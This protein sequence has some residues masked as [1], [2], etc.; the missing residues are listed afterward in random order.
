MDFIKDL[1]KRKPEYYLQAK[2]MLLWNYLQYLETNDL[3][4][5]SDYHNKKNVKE[6]RIDLLEQ[7][8]TDIYGEILEITKRFEVLEKFRKTHKILKNNVKYNAVM[9][10]IKSIYEY[11]N[12]LGREI[13]LEKIEMIRRW[14]YKISQDKDLFDQ[15]D[16][17]AKG[18]QA[19]KTEVEVLESELIKENKTEKV[20]FEKQR[21]SIEMGLELKIPIDPMKDSVERWFILLVELEK[22]VE[23]LSK[24][25]N[26]K[27]N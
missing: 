25:N 16:K 10:L 19:I 1:V 11:D 20:S 13:L 23:Y 2:D 24:K 12:N 21:L 22:K 4:Y 9:D 18:L 26:G 6:P 8:M 7:N 27:S 5:F 17:I 3:R 15:L 14:G